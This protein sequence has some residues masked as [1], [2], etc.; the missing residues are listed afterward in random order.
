MMTSVRKMEGYR[1]VVQIGLCV[2]LGQKHL[3]VELVVELIVEL[4]DSNPKVGKL[5]LEI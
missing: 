4:F 1:L 3:V 5:L 2:W